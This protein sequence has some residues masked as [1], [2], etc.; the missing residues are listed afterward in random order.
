MGLY[1]INVSFNLV[2]APWNKL[3]FCDWFF[4]GEEILTHFS[5]RDP[6]AKE[7]WGTVD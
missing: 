2:T 7:V 5:N 3:V 6:V 4:S 1:M